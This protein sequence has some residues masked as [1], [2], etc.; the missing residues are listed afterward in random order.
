MIQQNISLLPYNTFGIDAKAAF[1][2]EVFSVPELQEVLKSGI[3]PVLVLGGGSNM[4]LTKDVDGLVVKN[5][6][7]GIQVLEG[8]GNTVHV[9]AGAGI[10]WHD[11]VCWAVEH[12]FGGIENLSLIPG[13]VGASPVQNIGAYGVELKDVFVDLEAVDL[14]TGSVKIFNREA[15]RFGYRDSVFKHEEKGKYC[16]TSVTFALTR[17]EH[18]LNYSYG[19]IRK[20][21]ETNGIAEPAIGDISR[22]IIQIRSSKLPDPA[23]IGNC[24]SFFK[25]PETA[26]FVLDKIQETHPQVVSYDLPDGRVKIPAG[27]LIEQCGWKGKRVGNTGCYEKQAL[28]LVNHGGATG[29]EVKKLA[30]EIIDSVEKTFGIRLEPEVNII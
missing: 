17:N 12:H 27:W 8:E 29:E 6:I 21:L 11:L 10:V 28:V 2:T 24:G 16:I 14:N 30:Y 7:G 13:T 3:R 20:T 22:A 19:D 1:F 4:L 9:R 18:F 15:C 25:N 5:S 23:K 26:R